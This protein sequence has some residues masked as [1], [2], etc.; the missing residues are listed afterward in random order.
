MA[1]LKRVVSCLMFFIFVF[2]FAITTLVL[3][4][5]QEIVE[6]TIKVNRYG[7]FDKDN[8]PIKEIRVPKRALLKIKVEYAE[9]LA[10]ANKTGNKHVVKF[11]SE[12]TE[13][14]IISDKISL[15]K[16]TAFVEFVAGGD[17]SQKYRFQCIIYCI[18][19]KNLGYTYSVYIVVT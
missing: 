6:I 11:F 1:K 14:E 12:E 17:G 3:A 19:M 13:F 5:D 7:F 15:Q 9:S 18:G 4:G 16:K 2:N 10:D 8:Q